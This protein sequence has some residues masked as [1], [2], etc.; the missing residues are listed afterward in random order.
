MRHNDEIAVV[1]D[2]QKAVNERDI[3]RLLELSDPEI[4]IVGPRGSAHG[5]EVLRD[6]AA[7]AG[8]SLETLRTFAR[9]NAVVVAQHGVWRDADTKEIIGESDVAT[10]F[11]VDKGRVAQLARHDGADSLDTALEEAGLGRED[12]V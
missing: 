4:E 11:R 5:H 7:G 9:G 10:R 3:N 1:R 12:E 8:L 2:W 6:W